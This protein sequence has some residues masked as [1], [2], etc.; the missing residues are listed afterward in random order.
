MISKRIHWFYWVILSLAMFILACGSNSDPSLGLT[1]SKKN[2]PGIPHKGALL[3]TR[4]HSF[5]EFKKVVNV[6]YFD[7]TSQE[8]DHSTYVRLTHAINEKTVTSIL[9][10][11]VDEADFLKAKDGGFWDKAAVGIRSPFAVANKDNLIKVEILARRRY[12][13]FGEGDIA[14]YDLAESLVKNMSKEDVAQ[15]SEKDL[16]EKGYLNTFNHITA[17]AFMTSLFSEELADFIAD[18]HE[19]NTLPA[20]RTGKFT[21]EQLSD[22]ENGA[23]DNY[24]D[25][26]NNEWGQ[27]LGKELRKKYKITEETTWTPELLADYLNDMQRYYSWALEIGFKPFRP[28]D[29]VLVRFAGKLNAV[30]RGEVG[31]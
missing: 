28:E 23:V 2:I 12:V 21:P 29:D 20:L 3:S 6:E 19:R 9:G 26:V 17:Q 10:Y 8:D 11:G 4:F 13:M 22:I 18:V 25:M 16:S 27:E 15:M 7:T 5:E 14:F 30:M 24:V 1:S 31:Y